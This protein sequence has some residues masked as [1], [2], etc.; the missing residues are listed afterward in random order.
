MF[1]PVSDALAATVQLQVMQALDQWLA[2]VVNVVDVAVAA[3]TTPPS[4]RAR[5]R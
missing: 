2:G 4:S 1:A 3:P 5:C